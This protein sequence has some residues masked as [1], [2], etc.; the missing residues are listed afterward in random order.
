MMIVSFFE[1]TIFS[2][3]QI[4]LASGFWYG[5][6]RVCRTNLSAQHWPGSHLDKLSG[7]TADSLYCGMGMIALMDYLIS[8]LPQ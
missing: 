8:V 1:S 3:I 7:Q 2:P 4:G 5:K 6:G